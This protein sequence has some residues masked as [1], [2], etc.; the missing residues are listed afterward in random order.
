MQS[1]HG[2]DIYHYADIIDFSANI[3]PLGTPPSV[4]QAIIDSLPEVG[5]YPDIYCQKLREQIAK[6][7]DVDR[8][9]VI[10]GNGAADLIFR[11]VLA[12]QPKKALVLAPCFA[13]YEQALKA[14]GAKV[15]HYK[16]NQKTFVL[17]A[18]Y[19]KALTD[20]LDMVCLCN[21]NNPTGKTID[22]EL[23]EEVVIFCRQKKIWL[24]LDECF[25]DFLEDEQARTYLID[26]DK[27]AYLFVL[28]AFT[29][30]YAVPGVRLG[31]G[32]CSD[33]GLLERMYQAGPPWNVSTLAQ[34][35]G[36]AALQEEKF[37]SQTRAYVKKEKAYLYREFTRLEIPYWEGEANYIFFRF[38]EGLKEK[39]IPHGILIRDCGNYQNLDSTYYRIAVKTRECNEKLIEALEKVMTE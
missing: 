1:I 4:L 30:M 23:L 16:L 14:V 13:E 21:P 22:K 36:I 19:R 2:G 29:K 31:Y 18:D 9:H 24:L 15:K 17:G 38:K 35:A 26:A 11:L 37:V 12:L 8:E 32:V 20:N 39:M 7:H 34:T 6:F 27:G 3:N 33:T 10:C 25:L 28:R 5:N